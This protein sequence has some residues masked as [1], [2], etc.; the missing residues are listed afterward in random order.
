[1]NED[2]FLA[3]NHSTPELSTEIFNLGGPIG[4]AKD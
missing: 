3:K 2:S 4:V 1:M